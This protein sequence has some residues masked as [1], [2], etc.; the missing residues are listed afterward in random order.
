MAT[1]VNWPDWFS[2]M[3][4]TTIVPE[5]YQSS[6]ELRLPAPAGNL[7]RFDPIDGTARP[8]AFEPTQDGVR[9]HLNFGGF[10]FALL[11]W[12][13][14]TNAGESAAPSNGGRAHTMLTLSDRWTCRYVP[15]LPQQFADVLDP[16]QPELLWPHT[17]EVLWTCPDHG[18]ETAATVRA[19]FGMRAWQIDAAHAPPKPITWSPQFG[20]PQDKL[21]IS[22]LGP[23]GY[24]PEE[25]IDLG[26]F[27]IGQRV[28]VRA[29]VVSDESRDAIFA[30][31]ANARKSA[32]ISRQSSHCPGREYLWLTPV[33]LDRGANSIEIVL[34]A[35][36]DGS[37][38]LF[39]CFLDPMCAESFRRPERIATLDNARPGSVVSYRRRFDVAQPLDAGDLKVSA[40]AMATVF[41][42]DRQRGL[43][44][45]FDPYRLQMRGQAYR[46]PPLPPGPHQLRIE[47]I[48]PDNPAPL[49]V[50]FRAARPA[51]ADYTLTSDANWTV[52]V[53]DSAE[54]P[55]HVYSRQ[56]ADGAA[57]HLYRRAHPL[58]Q[59]DWLRPQNES[60]V[61]ALP[62]APP[63]EKPVEQSFEWVIPPGAVSMIL[64]LVDAEAEL[65]V[66]GCPLTISEDGQVSFPKSS[67]PSSRNAVLRVRSRQLAGGVFA[68][69]VTYRFEAGTIRLGSWLNHGL[70]SYSGAM[71][72]RDTFFLSPG[73]HRDT[74]MLNLGRVRGTVEAKLNGRSLGVRCFAPYSFDL[75]GHARAGTNELELLVTNTLV[76]H[77]STWSPT[78]WW[79]P[80][81][82]ECG[83]FGPVYLR[84]SPRNGK[85]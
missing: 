36:R 75:S 10:P 9:L 58:P 34:E 81:Q 33:R 59:T 64:P 26:K 85:D 68:S 37:I 11:V 57:W 35:E 76:N 44:G 18:A 84:I 8:L 51:G 17:T 43:Q 25:F 29:G 66:D 61:L 12:S 69:A 71:E 27:K 23:K 40:A 15:T 73:D 55:V 7:W 32:V 70:R 24:V 14:S 1:E 13:D 22:T 46:T 30:I 38:R 5:R 82:L 74:V 79:S 6:V 56:D 39:W 2:P 52:A 65:L 80:D 50:D 19:T 49:M 45:G 41:L 47:V 28:T 67:A 16:T 78:R 31:G 42:D 72:M 4:H 48:E 54:H 53:D 20:I 63:S 77:L 83:V 60:P 21:H 62:L 3:Q